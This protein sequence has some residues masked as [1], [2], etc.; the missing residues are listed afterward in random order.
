MQVLAIIKLGATVLATFAVVWGPFLLRP[1]AAGAVLSRLVPLKRGLFED[2]VANF[3][4]A[5]HLV[6]K[7]KQLL[8]LT[9]WHMSLCASGQG[10]C[11]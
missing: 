9:V 8:S 2:Y 6:V 4:C 3:W 1:G 7:W 11:T 10:C 5:T